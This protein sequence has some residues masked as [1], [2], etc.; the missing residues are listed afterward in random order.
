MVRT[1]KKFK[2]RLS[3][4]GSLLRE[5]GS[6]RNGCQSSALTSHIAAGAKC[7]KDMGLHQTVSLV[8]VAWGGVDSM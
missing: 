5:S 4:H 3:Y 1:V 7:L 8:W 6:N 2:G